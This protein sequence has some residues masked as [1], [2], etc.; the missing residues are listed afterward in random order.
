MRSALLPLTVSLLLNCQRHPVLVPAS[1]PTRQAN[2]MQ[3]MALEEIDAPQ[4]QADASAKS[5][6]QPVCVPRIAGRIRY[7]TPTHGPVAHYVPLK[8]AVRPV[9]SPALT[10]RVVASPN[11]YDP[12]L[13]EFFGLAFLIFGALAVLCVLFIPVGLTAGSSGLVLFGA[14]GAPVSALL[15]IVGFITHGQK[16]QNRK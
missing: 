1:F 4:I 6:S 7:R 11:D 2:A 13:R 15:A 12:S 16:G 3:P 9:A 10:R 14:I 5:P 8:V